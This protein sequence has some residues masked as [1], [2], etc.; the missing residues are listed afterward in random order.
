M[1]KNSTLKK[2]ALSDDIES[3]HGIVKLCIADS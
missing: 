2:I 3:K 1:K